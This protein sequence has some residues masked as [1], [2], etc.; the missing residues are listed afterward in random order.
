MEAVVHKRPRK[1][2]HRQRAHCNPLSDA[3]IGYPT[4]VEYVDW[5]LHYPKYFPFD[6]STSRPDLVVNTSEVPLDYSQKQP[7]ERNGENGPHISILDM[8]CGY[9]RLLF[10]LAPEMPDKLMLGMEIRDAVT[11]FVGKKILA[12]RDENRGSEKLLYENVGVVRTNGMKFLSNYIRPSTLEKIFFCFP[13]PQFKRAKWRRRIIS[14]PL[15]SLYAYHMKPD[16]LLYFV[17]DVED[18]YQWMK[19]CC[20]RHPLFEQVTDPKILGADFAYNA[21]HSCTDEGQKKIREG[22]K[23]QG[24]M[25]RCIKDGKSVIDQIEF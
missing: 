9:G 11:S 6:E 18:L 23:I 7:S 12:L 14:I 24:A 10:T 8:G 3:Y 17:S 2:E 1:G 16:G 20:D 22:C 25:Y 4:S 19:D 13:D 5:S 15:L 21:M